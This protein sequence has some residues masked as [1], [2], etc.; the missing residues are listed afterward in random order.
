MEVAVIMP[1][2]QTQGVLLKTF[3]TAR[4][5]VNTIMSSLPDAE[6]KKYQ[7]VEI[8][9]S[10]DGI[11]IEKP[12]KDAAI[13]AELKKEWNQDHSY[14]YSLKLSK[15]EHEVIINF[16]L[17]FRMTAGVSQTR[18]TFYVSEFT[19]VAFLTDQIKSLLKVSPTDTRF[20]LMGSYGGEKGFRKLSKE[21]K[22]WTLH[23]AWENAEKTFFQFQVLPEMEDQK[24]LGADKEGYIEAQ[25]L[26]FPPTWKKRWASLRGTSIFLFKEKGDRDHVLEIHEVDKIKIVEIGQKMKGL[27]QK[28]GFRFD[29]VSEETHSIAVEDQS[30][31]TSWIEAIK[32][33]GSRRDARAVNV[34]G[35]QMKRT[36]IAIG[37]APPPN[38]DA[39]VPG[40]KVEAVPEKTIDEQLDDV[41]KACE[42]LL[43]SNTQTLVASTKAVITSSQTLCATA[44]KESAN[45]PESI[46]DRSD[47]N[48]N[49]V[50]DKLKSLI[51]AA[52]ASG[53]QG[54]DE[55]SAEFK[56]LK[57]VTKTI[58]E[59]C[60][61]L[62]YL[63]RLED[64]LELDIQP[65]KTQSMVGLGQTGNAEL[66]KIMSGLAS[67][68]LAPEL[69]EMMQQAASYEIPEDTPQ[70][71]FV[72][73]QQVQD[74]GLESILAN[75]NN[76]LD[77][78]D[79]ISAPKKSV[80]LDS[81]S[82]GDEARCALCFDQ[83]TGKVVK[84]IGKSWHSH[85]FYCS[86]CGSN[87]ENHPASDVFEGPGGNPYCKKDFLKL[88]PSCPL[89]VQPILPVERFPAFNKIFH[90]NCF[91]CNDCKNPIV[92]GFE[93]EDK[94]F[95]E[96]CYHTRQG[97]LCIECSKP[98]YGNAIT[99]VGKKRHPHCFICSFC[100]KQ[101]TKE[102]TRAKDDKLFCN[103]CYAKLF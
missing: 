102:T 57:K 1:N 50:K 28:F 24:R 2:G 38:S 46:K 5:A 51:P 61:T 87:L 90:K 11:V 21:E 78:F 47:K 55:S 22:I 29:L 67:F 37:S 7:L 84:G 36:L 18:E 17:Y 14:V 52:K 85:C 75:L 62:V 65:K 9:K 88:C 40:E 98:I 91:K 73:V 19:T 56:E 58:V 35:P 93:L 83:I 82:A 26:S 45:K 95:C 59:A 77:D 31:M 20:G 54:N 64:D 27:G 86:Q 63:S 43:K 48:V 16:N 97:T 6:R 12:L 81:W 4:D 49:I 70:Q 3:E 32:S 69:A 13:I 94:P 92:G 60:E 41:K 44:L 71:S 30:S 79:D 103:S 34:A 100:K 8:K 15:L 42:D 66:D 101:L 96:M 76:A 99:A 89:C 23:T 68:G 80:E 72:P 25:A 10:G 39:P 74:D 53:I 33:S